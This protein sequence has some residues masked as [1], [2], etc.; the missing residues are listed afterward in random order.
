MLPKKVALAGSGV[1]GLG[2]PE[3]HLFEVNDC[4]GGHM[5]T[6]PFT[7][8]GQSTMVDTEVAVMNTATYH[9]ASVPAAM[10]FGVSRDA[11]ASDG[12]APTMWRMLFDTIRFNALAIDLPEMKEAKEGCEEESIRA[13][14]DREGYSQVFRDDYLIPMTE[15]L[16]NTSL[17]KCAL[18]KA[19]MAYHSGRIRAISTQYNHIIPAPH[20]DQ[21]LRLLGESATSLEK[22]ILSCFQTNLNTSVHRPHTPV[23]LSIALPT[24][25][26]SDI[27]VTLNPLAPPD[28]SKVQ[29]EYTYRHPLHTP[30]T[31]ATQNKR[32]MSSA[33]AWTNCGFHEGGFTCG[34]RVGMPPGGVILCHGGVFDA[35]ESERVAVPHIP[36]R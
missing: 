23:L 10:T 3:V 18:D 1:S 29:G 34:L 32:G 24:S 14:P 20:D 11:G 15:A 33:G 27:L 17:D 31:V 28:S 16:W 36:Y 21:A 12:L 7:Y 13:H 9:I 5:N 6:V 25:G 2:P 30:Q 26:H 8:N 4:I 35:K 22:D 19:Q